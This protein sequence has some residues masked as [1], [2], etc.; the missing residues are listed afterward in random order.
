M[1]CGE[2][3]QAG[4][5]LKLACPLA[6]IS[7]PST[8]RGPQTVMR[9]LTR[10]PTFSDQ[11]RQES[12]SQQAKSVDDQQKAIRR[13]EGV[14]EEEKMPY[15]EFRKLFE[16]RPEPSRWQRITLGN[17]IKWALAGGLCVIAVLLMR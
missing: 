4:H 13:P 14:R 16:K 8:A 3:P 15:Q 11:D 6:T 1:L 5:W 2:I 12:G 7:Q 9:L 17:S 10:G